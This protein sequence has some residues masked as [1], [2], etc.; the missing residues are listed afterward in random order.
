M[1]KNQRTRRFGRLEALIL[2]PNILLIAVMLVY[3][4]VTGVD[5]DAVRPLVDADPQ[6]T[7][8][9]SQLEEALM[10]DPRDVSKAIQ[11]S[12]LYQDVGEFP[13]S[14]NALL[15]AEKNSSDNP[16]WRLRLGLAY[17][18][19]GKND[20]GLRVMQK[21]LKGCDPARCSSN[22]KIKLQLFTRVA[23]LLKERKIDTRKQPRAAHK[24]LQDVFKPVV[25]EPEKMRPKGPAQ[26][27]QPEQPA[28]KVEPK[29]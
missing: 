18:E 12:R 20:D 23:R 29:S 14:Y 2:I 13:W 19:L 27:A 9:I 25:I 28:P 6:T 3:V 4:A 26:P 5:E 16:V 24:A 11:L 17:L 10:R 1:P 21:A 8:R 7:A 22:V 15:N